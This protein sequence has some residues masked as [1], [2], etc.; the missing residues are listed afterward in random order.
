MKTTADGARRTATKESIS[1]IATQYA[2]RLLNED[3]L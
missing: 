3:N 1:T 2:V